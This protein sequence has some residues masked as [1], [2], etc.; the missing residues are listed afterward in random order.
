[1]YYFPFGI[2]LTKVGLI[3]K[4]VEI[5]D[6]M[7]MLG[8]IKKYIKYPDMLKVKNIIIGNVN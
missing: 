5:K 2:P 1:M 7:V 8:M 3:E 4:K 6:L